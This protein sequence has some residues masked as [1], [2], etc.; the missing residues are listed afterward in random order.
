VPTTAEQP[1]AKLVIAATAE[2]A[3]LAEETR[4]SIE[5]ASSLV[6]DAVQ[7]VA[8]AAAHRKTTQALR[9]FSELERAERSAT[10]LARDVSA[11]GRTFAHMTGESTEP[12][13]RASTQRSLPPVNHGDSSLEHA[14]HATVRTAAL[15]EA[16][17][18]SV[19]GVSTLFRNAAAAVR[20]EGL[21]R[22]LEMTAAIAGV[23]AATRDADFLVAG[24]AAAARS[25]AAAVDV[26]SD[27]PRLVSAERA[28]VGHLAL[29]GRGQ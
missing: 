20:S 6:R 2:A 10:R 16:Q 26:T 28:A 13:R 14:L 21:T 1:D 27:L 24:T 19:Q 8:V 18:A 17:W 23:R 12:E 4:V 5:R 7:L 29:V 22:R 9:A 11:A 3:A 25:L 15:A